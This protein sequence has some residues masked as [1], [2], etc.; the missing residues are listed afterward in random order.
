[1]TAPYSTVNFMNEGESKHSIV[2]ENLSQS[3]STNKNKSKCSIVNKPLS[4]KCP[5]DDYGLRSTM[6]HKSEC[7]IMQQKDA[8]HEVACDVTNNFNFSKVFEC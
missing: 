3:S 2:N 7:A 1:M 6:E 4:Q 8:K 5:A